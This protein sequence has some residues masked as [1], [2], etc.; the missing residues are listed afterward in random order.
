M[1]YQK[2]ILFSPNEWK[3]LQNF[4]AILNKAGKKRKQFKVQFHDVLSK[5]IQNSGINCWLVNT[6]SNNYFRCESSQRSHCSP[7]WHAKYNCLN[8]NC[9]IVFYANIFDLPENIND[10]IKV[11]IDFENVADHP[12][13]IKKIRC[14]GNDRDKQKMKLLSIGTSNTLNENIIQNEISESKIN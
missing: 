7:F 8:K 14:T 13:C 10:D 2:I 5:K 4:V 9:K 6:N 1:K 12:K 3:S 11:F